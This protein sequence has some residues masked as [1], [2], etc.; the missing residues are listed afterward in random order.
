MNPR[1]LNQINKFKGVGAKPPHR[2]TFYGI[3]DLVEFCYSQGADIDLDSC[4][5]GFILTLVDGD[6]NEYN[7]SYKPS[8]SRLVALL[9]NTFGVKLNPLGCGSMHGFITI[10][11]TA[12]I[13]YDSLNEVG[14]RASILYE[15]QLKERSNLEQH[16]KNIDLA[17]AEAQ[18]DIK[19]RELTTT[20]DYLDL[21][22]GL[23]EPD[24]DNI[25]PPKWTKAKI[26]KEAAK[27]DIDMSGLN[28]QKSLRFFI[29]TFKES[30]YEKYLKTQ[31]IKI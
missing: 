22:K 23:Q 11:Y 20:E 29:S 7:T 6:G 2:I 9:T 12:E 13:D 17:N 3:G 24:W 28:K 5:Y 31:E 14:N 10:S 8:I 16:I 19:F 21:P 1:V 27:F 25:K 15:K 18:E 30:L 26:I 4:R